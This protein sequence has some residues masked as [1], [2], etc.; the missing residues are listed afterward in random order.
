MPP[1][2]FRKSLV[3]SGIYDSRIATAGD[4]ATAQQTRYRT[5]LPRPTMRSAS[6]DAMSTDKFLLW[7]R[8]LLP[9]IPP[10]KLVKAAHLLLSEPLSAEIPPQEPIMFAKDP[11]SSPTHSERAKWLEGFYDRIRALCVVHR[12]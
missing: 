9:P 5:E 2:E 4:S 11:K 10:E 6:G 3:T 1:L 8:G 12:I 7:G